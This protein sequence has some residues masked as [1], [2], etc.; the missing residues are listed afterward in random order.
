MRTKNYLPLPIVYILLLVFI[1]VRFYGQEKTLNDFI[2][3]G[4]ANSPLLNDYRN[5]VQSALL[6]SARIHAS[7]LP[8]INATTNNSYAPVIRGFGYDY[9]ITNGT[10]INAVVGVNKNFVGSKN[11]QNQYNTIRLSSQGIQNTAKISEQDL[12]RNII[13]Q[14]IVTYGDQQQLNLSAEI[15]TL[16]KKEDTILKTLAQKN[17]YKQTDYLAFL[18][19]LQQQELLSIQDSIQFRYDFA[20]LNYLCGIEDTATATLKEPDV[21]L[22]SLTEAGNSV[23]FRQYFLDSLKLENERR[24]IDLT[25]KP[26]LNVFADAGYIS[27]LAYNAYKNFGTSFGFGVT[28]PI[29]DGKQKKLQYQKLDIAE[30]T[31]QGYRQFFSKQYNQQIRQLYDQLKSTTDLISQINRQ[32]RYSEGLVNASMKL[33][34]T[35]DARITDLVIALNNYMTTRNLLTQNTISRMQIINQLNYWTR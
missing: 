12:K 32:I 33:L 11:L 27:S 20:S 22:S 35:G 13:S 6:D 25:Y 30:K 8:Q 19:T 4:L 28:I 34:V 15:Y 17:V 24:A 23:F 29:Y 18:V 14:Y 5:Q 3:I 2:S 7:Y 1:P 16:L 26:K 31:R 21:P 10:N 9:A